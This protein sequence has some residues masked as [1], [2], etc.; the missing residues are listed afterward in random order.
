MQDTKYKIKTRSNKTEGPRFKLGDKVIKP[1]RNG[2]LR[3]KK[4]TICGRCD[5]KYNNGRV[6][7][8][9]WVIFDGKSQ[10]EQVTQAMLLPDN[11]QA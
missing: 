2:T 7:K 11:G 3:T 8:R 9:Y 5:Q 10:P 1:D 6:H 4:G